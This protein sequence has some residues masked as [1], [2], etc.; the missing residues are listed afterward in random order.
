MRLDDGTYQVQKGKETFKKFKKEI[1]LKF[2]ASNGKTTIICVCFTKVACTLLDMEVQD[3]V[4]T[5]EAEQRKK[6]KSILYEERLL[7][8]K[9]QGENFLLLNAEDAVNLEKEE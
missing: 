1:R 6:I 5:T 8:L 3:F 4:S 7:T 2:T 9:N